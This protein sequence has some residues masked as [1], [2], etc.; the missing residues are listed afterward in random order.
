MTWRTIAVAV[1]FVLLPRAALAEYW[2][3]EADDVETRAGSLFRFSTRADLWVSTYNRPARACDPSAFNI[4]PALP[5]ARMQVPPTTGLG[6]LCNTA[7]SDETGIGTG[8]EASFRVIRPI[9]VFAGIDLVYTLPGRRGL[10]HQIV[11]PA[12]FGILFTFYEWTVRPIARATITPL[13]YLTDDARDYTLGGDLGFAWRVLDWGDLSF[14]VGYK[15]AST[16]KSIQLE[17]A[18]HPVP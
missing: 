4:A 14:T 12:P 18:V 3:W 8:I 6:S 15:T 9:H 2:S 13:V 17:I 7:H 11:I 10:K 16:I 5:S 1:A